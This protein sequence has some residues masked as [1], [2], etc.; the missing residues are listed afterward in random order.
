[1]ERAHKRSER[2]PRSR[3]FD[4]LTVLLF[5]AAL[6][7]PLLD[8]Y[9]LRPDLDRSVQ[10]EYRMPAPRPKRPKNA[11]ALATY[12]SRFGD[13]YRDTFGL[14][15]HLLRLHA[16]LTWN[17]FALSPTDV[18]VRGKDSIGEG[19]NAEGRAWIFFD[20]DHVLE[21]Q[22][23]D[24]PFLEQDLV[25][26][27][28]MFESR[29]DWCVARGIEYLSVV[30]PNKA[31][32]YPEYLPAGH[33]PGVSRLDQ[34]GQHLREFSDVP[35]LDLKEALLA[36]KADDRPQV[37]DF[38]YRP[39]GTH[40]T[41]RGAY[42]GLCAIFEALT[43]RVPGIVIKTREAYELRQGAPD[44]SDFWGGRLYLENERLPR[45]WRLFDEERE[46]TSRNGPARSRAVFFERSSVS[47]DTTRT[48]FVL[49]DSF[50]TQLRELLAERF[51]SAKF[52]WDYRF[53][54]A[55]IESFS[56][57]LF[58]DLRVERALVFQAP[59]LAPGPERDGAVERFE[60]SPETLWRAE[61]AS[62]LRLWKRGAFEE[63]P[64]GEG[65]VLEAKSAG[66]GLLLPEFDVPE[67]G[68]LALRAEFESPSA[69]TA[70]LVYRTE[71]D[72]FLNPRKAVQLPVQE[73]RNDLLFEVLSS[74]LEGRALLRLL[75]QKGRIVVHS[76][77][78]RSVSW[79]P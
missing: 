55:A 16:R 34:L 45:D 1:M 37:G 53:D 36:A 23:G 40:W 30:V 57:D 31:E 19:P 38:L 54:P 42:T 65:F 7:A 6:L 33:P 64:S 10:A 27:Q 44:A 71:G 76:L 20:E 21:T 15:D 78:A 43:G 11:A 18:V 46:L 8:V 74:R 67:E 73:G 49:H 32:I 48:V 79:R 35:F 14:R 66:T 39:L 47:T 61:G 9:V 4:A 51:Q 72:P 41:D 50:G 17:A 12:P 62:G 26:W 77:E 2:A 25:A 13:W 63:A 28:R 75:D 59:E 29:R 70:Y 56:P 58:L 3:L 22:R 24:D 52:V 69:G 60:K 5:A 68:H